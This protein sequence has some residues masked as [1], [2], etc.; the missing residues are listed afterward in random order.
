MP[1]SNLK[2]Y[3]LFLLL[4]PLEILAQTGTDISP[5][6]KDTSK[7]DITTHS[8]Y[9]GAG[10]GSN[11]VYLGSTISQN[12][13]YGYGS[14]TYGFKNQ[15]YASVSAVHLSGLNPFLSF[16]IGA[17]NYSHVFNN[18]F[19]ISAGVSRYQVVPSLTDTLFNSFTYGDITLGFD[20][21]LLYSKISVG[22]LFSTESQAFFQFKNSRYFQTPELFKGKA[23]ISFDPYINLLLGTVT[24]VE[25]NSETTSYYSISSP[26][27]KWRNNGNGSTTST[28]YTYSDRFGFLEMDFGLPVAFNTD[29]MTIEVEPLYVIPFYD[30]TYYLST[31]G[32]ILQLSI[33]F[34]IF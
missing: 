7:T 16:Y 15:L 21:K 2:Y 25:T 20:W 10:Y 11:M 27:R 12:Q 34:R 22:G 3:Y 23:S 24:E 19:D 17:L 14:L 32:F 18:W 5:T 33:F 30:D 28:T 31:K 4:L 29:F 8:F 13:P 26:Y 6:A 1:V 9:S